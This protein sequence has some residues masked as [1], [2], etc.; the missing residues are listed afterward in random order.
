DLGTTYSLIGWVTPEG[1]AQLLPDHVE[2]EVFHTPSV[3]HIT[4]RAAFV[5]QIAETLLEER[6]E[7]RVLRFFKRHFGEARPLFFDEESRPWHAEAIGALVLR[8]LRFDAESYLSSKI[9]GAVISVPAHFSDPQ[10]RAVLA[11]ASLAE[12]PVLGLIEEPVAA[13]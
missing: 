9:D 1:R 6:P 2:R 10:R 5:G 7:L 12:I 3:V 13:A 11:A 4:A 8:K